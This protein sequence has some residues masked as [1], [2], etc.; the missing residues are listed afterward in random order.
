MHKRPLVT[1]DR[2]ARAR[3]WGIGFSRLTQRGKG[4]G[5]GAYE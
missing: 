2:D 1:N 5:S 3:H 4:R